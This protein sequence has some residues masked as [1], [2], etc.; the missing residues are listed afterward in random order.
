MRFGERDA[1]GYGAAYASSTQYSDGLG[2]AFDD[3]FGSGFDP[4]QD[5]A[6]ISHKSASV[7]CST[8]GSIPPI[9]AALSSSSSG[10]KPRTVRPY[11]T[12]GAERLRELR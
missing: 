12:P 7:M 8:C 9:I 1:L 2:V 6:N 4:L 10:A 5:G 11:V 3:D